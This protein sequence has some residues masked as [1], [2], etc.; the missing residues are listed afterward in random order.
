L[1]RSQPLKTAAVVVPF[2]VKLDGVKDLRL[3]V[4]CPGRNNWAHSIWLNPILTRAERDDAREPVSSRAEVYLSEIAPD[5]VLVC[6]R[7]GWGFGNFGRVGNSEETKITVKGQAFVNGIGAHP[8]AGR[9]QSLLHYT[10]GRRF[11]ILR[12]AVALNDSSRRPESPVTFQIIG[13]GQVLWQSQEI[14]SVGVIQRFQIDVENVDSLQMKVKCAAGNTGCSA[15]WLDP[16]LERSTSVRTASSP[17]SAPGVKAGTVAARQKAEISIKQLFKDDYRNAK[18]P[19]EQLKFARKLLQH[20]NETIDDPISRYVLLCQ[21]R[22]F[23]IAAGVAKTALQ[24]VDELAA[25]FQVEPLEEK[26]DVLVKVTKTARSPLTARALAVESLHV[27]DEAIAVDHYSIALRLCRVASESAK[28]ARDPD[29]V[30][31]VGASQKHVV[32]LQQ[33]HETASAAISDLK[34]NPNN[35]N[36]NLAL[37]K[38]L[39]QKDKDWKAA[40]G[41]LAKGA[42]HQLATLAT[43]DLATPTVPDRQIQLADTWWDYST[44]QPSPFRELYQQRAVHWY[45]RALPR[46]MGLKKS[47][48]VKRLDTISNPIRN[49]WRFSAVKSWVGELHKLLGAGALNHPKCP[50]ELL[51]AFKNGKGRI[52]GVGRHDGLN[53]DGTGCG[54]FGKA[55]T[56]SVSRP[57]LINAQLMITTGLDSRLGNSDLCFFDST[58]RDVGHLHLNGLPGRLAVSVRYDI[59]TSQ[60]LV[61]ATD[62][63]GRVAT[64]TQFPVDWSKSLH[65]AL[66]GCVRRPGQKFDL[67]LSLDR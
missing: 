40:L 52:G 51:A 61:S 64:T 42:D 30:K 55:L 38:F 23:A 29:L 57:S 24:A 44:T 34:T 66:A 25:H 9:R 46:L 37:G 20:A 7:N 22:D 11:S 35:E 43:S 14:D 19:M 63:D 50:D 28:K 10:L 1:W 5:A 31:L 3:L 36:A 54:W 4:H 62:N 60:V 47:R 32:R 12:G 18:S 33:Q 53:I 49:A 67:Q 65:I 41:H 58:G 21:S 15:A 27:L 45:E 16:V 17:D 13:N 26:R 48:V 56:W 2:D 8:E 39:C 59:L 6:D